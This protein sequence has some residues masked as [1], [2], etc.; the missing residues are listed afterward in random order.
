MST[1]LF[2]TPVPRLEDPRLLSG[3]GRYV[4]DIALPGLVHGAF[5][6][7]PAAHALIRAIDATA[8]RAMPGVVAVYTAEDFKGLGAGPMPAMAPHP[9]LK[10]TITAPPLAEREV[11][12]A[13]EP[14]ALVVAASRAAAE[15]AVAAIELDL[16]HLPAV[17]DPRLAMATDAPPVQSGRASN[18]IATMRGQH[19]KV[20]E[21][22][23]GAAHRFTAEFALH[24][25][26]C[27]SMECR[28]V[29]AAPE[30]DGE[31][32]SLWTSSQSPYMVRRQ[33]AQYL[34]RDESTIRVAA[35]DVGGGFGPKAGVYPEEF[36]VAMAALLLRRPVK[37]IEDRQEHFLATTQQRD[38]YWSLEVACDASGKML[39][40]RGRCVHD[41]GAYAPYGLILPATALGA[42]PGPYALEAFDIAID[43]VLTNLVPTTPVRGAGRPNAAFVLER[44][45]D[46]VARELKLPREEVRR[47][48]FVRADQMPYATGNRMRDGSPQRYDS[49]DYVR[50][51]ELALEKID[52]KGF[53]Q[54]RSAAAARGKKLGLGLAS[55]VEDTGLGPFEGATVR[56]TPAGK[57]VVA[58]GA[59]GQ[60]QGHATTLAQIAADALGVAIKD[61]T[62]KAGDSAAF[63]LGISTIASRIAVTAGSS[64][65]VAAQ[66]VREKAAKVAA[67]MLECDPGDL[68]FA[69]GQVF[70][71]GSD[72]KVPLATIAKTLSGAAGVPLPKGIEPDL[73]ATGYFEAHQLAFAYGSQ[74]CEVELD[75][76]SGE[77][78]VTR[79]VVVH[80]CGRLINPMIVDGQIRGG[81]VHGIGNA[82][83]ERM[84]HDEQGQPLTTTYADYLLPA[85]AEMP[86]IEIHHLETPSPNNP[87]GVKGA[88]EGGTIPAAACVISAIEDALGERGP[89]IT[90]HPV[91]PET[92]WGWLHG[93]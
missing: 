39:G 58:T 93:S 50:A 60:G 15:D 57:V 38:Q 88:G 26:G 64:V 45:A 73:A 72:L 20:D 37:W 34:N 77:A 36:C 89:V 31:S 6:R 18:V 33:L 61:V 1:K 11:C 80:D 74:A 27:H 29:V 5:L 51:L 16:E 54:R 75:P 40:V 47:R 68:A 28:G 63:P 42:F 12:Y 66:K 79:Y 13:G 14:I 76:D 30:A 86:D 21:V 19:G 56:V 4:D 32:L 52:A 7:A 44:L 48:S 43:V 81:V 83:F 84:V 24:R 23:A 82:L 10:E 91:S 87:I 2:G 22:F 65:S 35:P 8:A 67:Q 41:N 62:V 25:G 53:A 90:A 9:L 49:G 69:D 78:R 46:R 70:V 55:C 71:E 3:G 92:I 17:A 85:A 59:A